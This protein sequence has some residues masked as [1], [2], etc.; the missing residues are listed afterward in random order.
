MFR[1]LNASKSWR[2]RP[3]LLLFAEHSFAI[4]ST[5]QNND[6]SFLLSAQKHT[7]STKKKKKMGMTGL[8]TSAFFIGQRA[9]LACRTGMVVRKNRTHWSHRGAKHN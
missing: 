3:G 7:D 9:D 5:M 6:F 4:G 8:T 2:A 1:L